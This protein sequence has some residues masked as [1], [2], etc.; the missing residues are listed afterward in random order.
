[1]NKMENNYDAILK[2]FNQQKADEEKK[3]GIINIQDKRLMP[4]REEEKKNYVKNENMTNNYNQRTDENSNNLNNFTKNNTKNNYKQ[5]KKQLNNDNKSEGDSDF[6]LLHQNLDEILKNYGDIE[7]ETYENKNFDNNKSNNAFAKVDYN[8]GNDMITNKEKIN[9]SAKV[10]PGNFKKFDDSD[11]NLLQ[12]SDEKKGSSNYNEDYKNY[13]P[14][15]HKNN[16]LNNYTKNFNK[17]QYQ[18]IKNVNYVNNNIYPKNDKFAQQRHNDIN[19]CN[20]NNIGVNNMNDY[21][22]YEKDEEFYLDPDEIKNLFPNDTNT[23]DNPNTYISYVSNNSNS[24]RN[25]ISN[26][27]TKRV[28]H[29]YGNYDNNSNNNYQSHNNTNNYSTNN[30]NNNQNNNVN[31]FIKQSNNKNFVYESNIKNQVNDNN[32]NYS[33]NK[34]N[35]NN[36]NNSNY[37]DTSNYKNKNLNTYETGLDNKKY[38][39]M[40]NNNINNETNTRNNLDFDGGLVVEDGKFIDNFSTNYRLAD[41]KEWSRDF[42][43]DELVD[44]ANLRVFGFKAFRPNQR[45]IINASLSGRDIFVCMPTGGGKSL[46]F[47]IPALISEGVTVVVMPLI[48]LIQDQVSAMTGL[49]VKV[50]VL[51]R[52]GQEEVSSNFNHYFT[53][54]DSDEKCKM[55]FVTPEKISQSQRATSFLRKLYKDG[56][57]DRFVID[58]AHCLSQW[59]RE[60]RPDYLNLRVLRKDYPK[61]PI[62]A[63]T[64]TAP[65]KI[66][67][68]II[69][70]LQMRDCLFF[71][72][73]YNRTN[74]YIEIRNK[75]GMNDIIGDMA[76]FINKKYPE[77]CGLIYC[78]SRKD[79]ENV[80]EKLRR[81]HGL[82]AHYYHASM[83][84]KLKYSVQEKWKNDEIKIIVATVAFGMGI[85]K[86][87]VRFVIHHAMPKSFENYY[88]EIGRAGRDGKKSHCI[89]YYN[90]ADRKTQEY[91]MSKSNLAP[92]MVTQNLRKITE[93]IDYCEENCECRRVIALLYFDENFNRNDC[94]KMCD[95]CRKNL[96]KEEKDITEDCLKILGFMN[97][98]FKSN[99]DMPQGQV[100]DYLRGLNGKKNKYKK[101]PQSDSHFGVLKHIA[102]D[103]IKKMLRRLIIL[104]YIDEKLITSGENPFVVMSISNEGID[105]IR[106]NGYKMNKNYNKPILITFPIKQI[107]A[108]NYEVADKGQF[109]DKNADKDLNDYCYNV[110]DDININQSNNVNQGKKD[111]TERKYARTRTDNLGNNNPKTEKKN[112][113]DKGEIVEDDYGFCTV[114]QFEELFEKLKVKRREIL[115]EE[116]KKIEQQNIDNVNQAVQQI[117]KLTVDDIFPVTG[118]KELCRKLPT[119]E[120]ELNT[121]Y[122]FGVG[123]KFLSKYGKEFLPEIIKHINLYEISKDDNAYNEVVN[124]TIAFSSKKKSLNPNVEDKIKNKNIEFIK[125]SNNIITLKTLSQSNN[126][127]N[128]NSSMS[129]SYNS[130]LNNLNLNNLENSNNNYKNNNYNNKYN[131]SN[132][133]NNSS[134][135]KVNIDEKEIERQNNIAMFNSMAD[136]SE[137]VVDMKSNVI[138]ANNINNLN[139]FLKDLEELSND[140][141][142]IIPQVKQINNNINNFN[143]NNNNRIFNNPSKFEEVDKNY[144]DFNDFDI[145][146]LNDIFQND[147]ENL[148]NDDSGINDNSEVKEE[149]IDNSLNEFA[150][151][152]KNL[153]KEMNKGNKKKRKKGQN[154]E[155]DDD[156]QVEKKQKKSSAN[157]YFKKKAMWNRI[158]K[159]KQAKKN[160]FI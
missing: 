133:L 1:M 53:H 17:N 123:A 108:N 5:E 84:E 144:D 51:N 158:N 70:Q 14:T 81:N 4:V 105:W 34:Y 114:D 57:I 20:I 98:C 102:N 50:L 129:Q 9:F 147:I 96:N 15:N 40:N 37:D 44:N 43:W 63:I 12:H 8:R 69:G 74:L 30:N 31:P 24:P 94:A 95:N 117:K 39:Q 52:E 155:D 78:S 120:T 46:T 151:Q 149:N 141:S 80:S 138:K 143:N 38:I 126:N 89:L 75:K 61:V 157:E 42:E 103:I 77:A 72:S 97:N 79:C 7:E 32:Y 110:E 142:K 13:F 65:N 139:N 121:N 87:D 152:V 113:A 41:L 3:K 18:P 134:F 122:I 45:E 92:K 47:Q 118:L 2:S 131:N 6:S 27:L 62:L 76:N 82:S 73:S 145:N 128:N 36:N 16:N 88:Q 109:I 100:V 112:K 106:K 148:Q 125:K 28:N 60:F 124:Q 91:L 146:N 26:N 10:P 135:V 154:E 116:N 101:Y 93:M 83:N 71:R 115:R 49:G 156:F 160:N 25:L 130:N 29:N 136:D 23:D 66:R 111:K 153:N 67:E 90:S 54:D 86:G 104:K 19:L 132:S 11:F 59:G 64:A 140:K 21:N 119:K 99:I 56:L 35:N 22:Q 48:S 127:I 150:N 137:I 55:L 159:A 107:A 85:N 58:E 33:N 68:D